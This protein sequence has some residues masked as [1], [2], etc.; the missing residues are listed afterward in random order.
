MNAVAVKGTT[1]KGAAVSGATVNRAAASGATVSGATVSA[2]ALGWVA[3]IALATAAACT[4]EDQPL[5]ESMEVTMEATEAGV[6]EAGAMAAS[7]ES[8][9]VLLPVG[10]DPTISFSLSFGVGSQDDPPGKEGLAYVTGKM[11]DDAST[12]NRPYEAIL[13]ALYPIASS[14]GVRV[15][16]EVTTLTG[17]THRDNIDLFF[18]LYSDAYL[19]PAFD[20]DDFQRI[21]S[22]AINYLENQLRFSS[23]E[24]L[25]KAALYEFVFTGTTYAHPTIGTV[26]GLQSITLDDVRQFYRRHYRQGNATPGLGGGFGDALGQRFEASLSGLPQVMPGVVI[27]ADS[28]GG[29]DEMANQAQ[30]PAAGMADPAIDPP[31]LAGREVLLVAKP[32]AD[33][34]ISFGFPIDLSRGERDF[35]ALWLANSWLGEH[36][37]QSSHLFEVIREIRGLNYGDYSYIEAFPDGGSLTMPPVNVPRRHRLFEVWIRTLPN[38]QAHFALR[39]A[40]RELEDLVD[41]GLTQEA[42][43]L[44]RSFLTKYILHFA[45]TTS[46]RLGYAMD[47]RFYGIGGDGHLA[48]FAQMLHELTLED[49]NAAIREHLQYE[50]LKIAIVT[51]DAEGLRAALSADAASPIE[52]E[53]EMPEDVLAEDEEISTLP[54][55]IGEDRIYTVP[56][57]GMFQG[58][59]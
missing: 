29:A 9:T 20:P 10:T 15:D 22:D 55:G 17:R 18:E 23:D 14:Y 46:Q 27:A 34:S 39:A 25:G 53:Q 30:T 12:E 37:N 57:E 47:D 56:V 13:E 6:T 21:E 38:H 16:R 31:A 24:E 59:G 5:D 2:R 51:G 32:G 41:N 43:D 26:E 49:V 45:V 8:S 3:C 33:A 35:Y 28:P 48:R 4:G 44:T 11:L 40:I 36:R 42:F 52:Y 19:R 7:P 54:L 50:N 1:V 58:G